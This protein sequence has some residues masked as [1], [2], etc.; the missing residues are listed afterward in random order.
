VLAVPGS[1]FGGAG[2]PR[3]QAKNN[4]GNAG[5][6]PATTPEILSGET[7]LNS[8]QKMIKAA[9]FA[10]LAMTAFL[11]GCNQ[12]SNAINSSINQ[13]SVCEVRKWQ[14]DAVSGECKT[15][16]KVVFLPEKWGNE[17]LP[18]LFAAVNC[19]LRYAVAMTMGAV[20]CIYLPIT[21]TAAKNGS[22]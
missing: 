4:P 17:Q 6:W 12:Q 15:G 1:F 19:D 16:Q 7:Q 20:T 3:G 14:H 2:L 11:S 18:I 5:G 22:E 10:T 8:T 13:E 9:L 21:P